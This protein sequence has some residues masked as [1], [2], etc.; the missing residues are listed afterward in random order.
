MQV[1][2][3]QTK[4][5]GVRYLYRQNFMDNGKR[6][7][8]SVTL[9]SITK[10]AQ[11]RAQIML[12]EKFQDRGKAEKEK[13]EA[14]S[15]T[16]LAEA[17]CQWLD[18]DKD[19][20]KGQTHDGHTMCT[21]QL[22]KRLPDGILTRDFT[23]TLAEKILGRMYYTEKLCYG[24]ILK[25]LAVIR[26]VMRYAEKQGI[27]ENAKPFADIHIKKRSATR[28]EIEKRQ[29]K[30]LN[31]DE[32]KQVL[33][34]L[35]KIDERIALICEFQSLTGL[36]IG[37]L[38]ALRVQDVDLA[39]KTI[40]INGGMVRLANKGYYRD[41]PKNIYSVR[42]ISINARCVHIIQWFMTDNKRLAS[43]TN[44]YQDQGY[45]FTGM[46]GKPT[47]ILTINNALRQVQLPGKHITS[48]IFRHT[49]ISML[50]AA[51]VPVKAIMKRVG[52]NNPNTTLQ[53]YTHVTES[54][55][56]DLAEKLERMSI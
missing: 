36:R 7:V 44:T 39:K 18:M 47:Y 27:I 56:K 26:G 12:W 53:I 23:P 14:A 54:M 45:I 50:A 42:T 28:Q 29:N 43:W 8:E 10:G 31:P 2:K 35:S 38:L 16:T 5:K 3:K 41:T 51:N 49:H 55:E 11:K 25:M 46:H 1:I 13:A 15:K 21:R 17:C 40:N 9:D 20:V 30:F 4:N 52:Q 48:H 32:L 33:R 19:L 34:Q 22:L 37:E 24:S 6:Y